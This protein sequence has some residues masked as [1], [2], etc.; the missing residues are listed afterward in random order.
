[1]PKYFT[2]VTFEYIGRNK[3]VHK[4]SVP[5]IKLDEIWEAV[6]NEL[7]VNGFVRHNL[8]YNWLVDGSNLC[9]AKILSTGGVVA[10]FRLRTGIKREYEEY[11]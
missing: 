9:F 6:E 4:M 7:A 11:K 3:E 1:V 2:E 5:S 10:Q 8:H